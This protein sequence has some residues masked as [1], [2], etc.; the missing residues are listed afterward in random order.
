MKK[1]IIV[2]SFIFLFI[3][4]YKICFALEEQDIGIGFILGNP[5]GF[6]GKWFLHSQDGQ[7]AIDGGIG[8]PPG[9][10]FYIYGDYLKHFSDIFTVKEL[11]PYLGIG[12]GFHHYEKE[13][14]TKDDEKENRL[15]ARMP[16]GLEYLTPKVPLGIFFELV[17]AL[18]FV[19]DIDFSIKGGL[20][21][22]F[23]L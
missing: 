6:T 19:P 14:N 16:L 15:E 12:V 9:E 22:R 4:Q 18:R 11:L 20:G 23:Y 2:I 5:F 13:Y 3:Y 1:I 8:D 17:P 10:G 21:A 7:D